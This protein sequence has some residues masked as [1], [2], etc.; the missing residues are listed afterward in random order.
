[1]D[2][3]PEEAERMLADG[4]R[5]GQVVEHRTAKESLPFFVWGVF[6]V[7]VI[8][9]F[10]YVDPHI[11]GWVTIAVAAVATV[12]TCWYMASGNLRVRVR[13]RTPW[14]AW[15]AFSIGASAIAALAVLF[16]EQ[17]AIPFTIAGLLIGIPLVVWGANLR[18]SR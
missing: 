15:P 17:L 16:D 13:E 3:T 18:R 2:I 4:R 8:P 7:A 11:W 10:D 12:L 5:A 14:W 6:H 9:G 1:M